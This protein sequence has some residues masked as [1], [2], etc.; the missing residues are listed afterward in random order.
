MRDA[1]CNLSTPLGYTDPMKTLFAIG[2]TCRR[3]LFA[4]VVS[5]LAAAVALF[6]MRRAIAG[7]AAFVA[8]AALAGL[9]LRL[10]RRRAEQVATIPPAADELPPQHDSPEI[11]NTA[12]SSTAAVTQDPPTHVDDL[13]PAPSE[14]PATPIV[15]VLEPAEP[16]PQSRQPK[17]STTSTLDFA[18][19][20][21]A[22][23]NSEDPLDELKRFVGD[24]RTREADPEAGESPCG[25]E[26]YAARQLAEAGLFASDIELPRIDVIRPHASNMVYLRCLDPRIPYLAKL[27]LIRLEAALN[28]IRFAST[29]LDDDASCEDAYRLNQRLAR[30]IAAQAT[31][32]D[33]SPTT[34]LDAPA[35][36][37]WAVR[38]GISQAIESLQLPYRLVASFRCNVADGNV[39]I[40]FAHMP[41]EVFPTSCYLEG[42]GIISTTGDM[43]QKAAADY[44]L[45]LALLLAARAFDC[46]ERINHV[47]VAAVLA[48][49]TRRT[50]YLSV[51]FDRWRFARLDLNDLGDLTELY[52]SFAPVMRYEEGWLRPIQQ[53]FHLEEERF[54]P[55]RRYLPVS[56]SS[57]RIRQD[58]ASRLGCD[59]VSAL[60]IEEADGRSL[61]AS[62]IML[63]LVS[64]DDPHATQ[65]NV[66][67][68]LDLAGDDPDPTVRSAAERVVSRLVA[69]TLDNDP[70]AIGEEFVRGD[71]LTRA[72]DRARELLI[73]QQ[74]DR[75]RA[76]IVPL[77]ARID[78]AGTYDDTP[79]ISYRYFGSYI[80]RALYN[81]LH[82]TSGNTSTVLLVPDAYYEAHL[83]ASITSLMC[84]EA[85]EACAHAE[86]LCT[87]AP[88]DGRCRLHLVSCLEQLGRDD[89]AVGELEALLAYAHHPM[90]VG[91]AYY[92]LAFFQWKRGNVATA[93][94]CYQLAMQFLPGMVPLMA[95][96]L[97]VLYLQHPGEIK[98]EMNDELAREILV[99]QGIPVA[100]TQETSD[101]FIECAQASLDA[102]IFPVAR[103]FAT[104]LGAFAGDDVIWG[105]VRSLEDAPDR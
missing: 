25:L 90:G 53:G 32:G 88:L 57:Q 59:H 36:G 101:A 62:T 84:G 8:G 97:S 67:T 71:V 16:V 35:D 13:V 61:V 1:T 44:A 11:R 91:F 14:S 24:I 96:E 100:P 102:E 40:E 15:E 6:A 68:I 29:A 20:S 95:M 12:E 99:A 18:A 42:S 75:A 80:E 47:W 28:A 52:R 65:K 41:A 72:T 103:A 17:P 81:R 69:G 7:L 45:R 92:R 4:A 82:A 2:P 85:H 79:H 56:L 70:L 23:V 48:N 34:I 51:D 27:R 63:R 26:R 22:L 86:R 89:E 78:K 98:P 105:L 38:Y 3:W 87:L 55:S 5:L 31:A 64:E 50:C 43:R 60:S 49:A 58:L 37:E 74:P 19:L 10:T 83:L 104:V 93:Q 73:H 66:R 46:S 33:P 30:S 94:A 54:C 9:F 39:A 76:V 77:L 21:T